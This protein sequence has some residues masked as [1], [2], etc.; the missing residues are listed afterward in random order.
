MDKLVDVLL[1]AFIAALAIQQ[2]LE[3]LDPLLEWLIKQHKKWILASVAL[4]FALIVTLALHLRLL[5]PFGYAE[6]PVLDVIIT[7]LFLT[8]GTKAINDLIKLIGYKKEVL[9]S[10]LS[11]E[12]VKRA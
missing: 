7:A 6:V 12:Q 10:A 9:K 4:V 11:A 5:A 1:P 3:F 8:G 2:L